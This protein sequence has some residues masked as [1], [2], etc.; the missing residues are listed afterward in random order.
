MYDRYDFFDPIL[1][2]PVS[3]RDK[4]VGSHSAGENAT[5]KVVL[6]NQPSWLCFM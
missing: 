4:M 1:Y 2:M 6:L 5:H 3:F